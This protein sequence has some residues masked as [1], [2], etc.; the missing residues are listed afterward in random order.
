MDTVFPWGTVFECLGAAV[1]ML[2]VWILIGYPHWRVWA[3]H[4][5]GLADLAQANNDQQIQIAK[6]KARKEAA[7]L[8]KDAAIIEAEAVSA[9]IEK[10][11]QQLTTHDLYLR[12][13]WI[14]M[15]KAHAEHEEGTTVIYV[16][17]EANLPVLEATRFKGSEK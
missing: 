2:L 1:F 13:Q 5:K 16:P 11:G 8:N 4:Q 17:T 7:T 14:E 6:A 12:W 10:I 15:M 9:Q 3:A